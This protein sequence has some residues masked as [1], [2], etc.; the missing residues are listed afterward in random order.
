MTAPSQPAPAW[1]AAAR[2]QAHCPPVAPRVPLLLG[3]E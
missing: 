2:R 3:R 1:V